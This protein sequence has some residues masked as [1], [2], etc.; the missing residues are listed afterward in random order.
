ML[1]ASRGG[2]HNAGAFIGSR[3]A[4]SAVNVGFLLVERQGRSDTVKDAGRGV[5]DSSPEKFGVNRS[6]VRG[7]PSRYPL[8]SGQ[9]VILPLETHSPVLQSAQQM[10][11]DSQAEGVARLGI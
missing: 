11:G 1:A 6:Q 3:A 2:F 5:L 4:L 9:R 8:R 7:H 10:T